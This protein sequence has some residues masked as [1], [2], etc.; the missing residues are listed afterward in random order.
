MKTKSFGLRVEFHSHAHVFQGNV[1]LSPIKQNHGIDEQSQQEIDNHTGNHDNQTL[2]GR[3]GT[4]LP[5][6]GRELHLLGVH[7]LVYHTGYFDITTQRQPAEAILRGRMLGLEFQQ[8][9]P[10]VE[11]KAELLHPHAKKLGGQEMPTF[12]QK[13]EN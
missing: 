7:G 3:M 10:R 5:R 4:E 12:V 13:D 11:E 1:C 6:F 8:R 9:L 2:P